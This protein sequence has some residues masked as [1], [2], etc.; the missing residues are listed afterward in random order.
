MC[1]DFN[2]PE[3][4]SVLFQLSH[5]LNKTS[6]SVLASTLKH[7]A[8][9]LGLLQAHPDEFLKSGMKNIDEQKIKSLIKDRQDAR[10]RRDF[11]EADRIRAQL[12]ADGIELE[13]NSLKTTW[14]RA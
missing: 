8:G 9:M 2:T 1:D 13:D 7:L 5:E 6:S 11:N 12:L 14:R 4:L 10:N 3:A